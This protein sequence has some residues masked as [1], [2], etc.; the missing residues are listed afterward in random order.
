M[1]PV[2]N[3]ISN[4]YNCMYKSIK[5]SIKIPCRN[6][7]CHTPLTVPIATGNILVCGWKAEHVNAITIHVVQM[8]S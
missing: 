3:K 4:N 1:S 2:G 7:I 8:R 6:I 5:P